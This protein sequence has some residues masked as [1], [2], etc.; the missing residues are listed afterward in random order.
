M[1]Q[2]CIMPGAFYVKQNNRPCNISGKL[3][4]R[5]TDIQGH[6]QK[7]GIKPSPIKLYFT[8]N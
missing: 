5:T 1:V 2:K 3:G 7:E 6:N 4:E 8:V